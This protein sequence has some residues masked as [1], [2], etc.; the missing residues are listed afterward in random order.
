MRKDGRQVKNNLPG[1][2]PDKP[3]PKRNRLVREITIPLLKK[4][5][6][7]NHKLQTNHNPKITNYK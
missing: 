4:R 7:V 2:G 6:G 1:H 5:T 3:E